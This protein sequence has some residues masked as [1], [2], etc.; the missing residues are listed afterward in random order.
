MG[1]VRPDPAR[2]GSYLLSGELDFATVPVLLERGRAM[3]A[4]GAPALRLDL[5]GVSRADSAGLALLI[6]WSRAARAAGQE[7]AFVNVPPQMFAMAR[8]TGLDGVLPLT[9]RT[10]GA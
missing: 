4:A 3:F 6:E 10:D 8:V 7:I 9:V 1:E 5:G 2:T